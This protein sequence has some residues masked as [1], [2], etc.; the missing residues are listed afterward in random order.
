MGEA[1]RTSSKSI[2]VHIFAHFCM[3]L[4][5]HV[6]MCACV[7]VCICAC[8]HV[9][10]YAPMHVCMQVRQMHRTENE[11]KVL[12]WYLHACIY[13]CVYV[14]MCVQT[15]VTVASHRERVQS[16]IILRAC[17]YVCMCVRV[18]REVQGMFPFENLFFGYYGSFAHICDAYINMM[19]TLI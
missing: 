1:G 5:T 4:Y 17:I 2:M 6:C 12:S 19:H 3:C 7:Y 11:F 16:L 18:H 15:G 9:F 14:C 8:V 13:A 10:I